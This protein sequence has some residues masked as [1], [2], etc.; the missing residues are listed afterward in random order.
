MLGYKADEYVG[1]NIAEFHVD[2]AAIDD[3]LKRLLRQE[4]INQYPARL[5]AKDGSIKRF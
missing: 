4:E 1:R 2:K 3:I 5:R